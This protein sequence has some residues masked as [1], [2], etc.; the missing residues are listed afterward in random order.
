VIRER[1]PA[2]PAARG[3]CGVGEFLSQL[4]AAGGH[5]VLNHFLHLLR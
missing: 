5:G 4:L 1:R 3:F 2:G